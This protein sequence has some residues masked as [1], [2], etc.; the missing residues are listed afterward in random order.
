MYASDDNNVVGL[1]HP[2]QE[3]SDTPEVEIPDKYVVDTMV[4]ERLEAMELENGKI[5]DDS[6]SSCG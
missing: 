3:I 6:D 5:Y 4:D 1:I 2:T